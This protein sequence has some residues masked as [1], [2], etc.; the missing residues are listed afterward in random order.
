MGASTGACLLTAERNIKTRFGLLVLITALLGGCAQTAAER[1]CTDKQLA[2][3]AAAKPPQPIE[4]EYAGPAGIVLSGSEHTLTVSSKGYNHGLCTI[5]PD[6]LTVTWD[7]LSGDKRVAKGASIVLHPLHAGIFFV[8]VTI[9]HPPLEPWTRRFTLPVISREQNAVMHLNERL[10]VALTGKKDTQQIL[11]SADVRRYTGPLNAAT[12]SLGEDQTAEA[13]RHLESFR[14]LLLD[15]PQP[16][17]GWA[18]IIEETDSII[19]GL[20]K[21]DHRFDHW[22]LSTEVIE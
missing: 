16:P 14:A 8:Q 20:R 19:E 5:P 17:S 1:L 21:G 4:G 2:H 18:A 10:L 22:A 11:Q 7:G 3:M 9:E 13:I 6:Q 15:Y 12:G